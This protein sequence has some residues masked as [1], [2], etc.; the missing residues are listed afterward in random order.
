ML[1]LKNGETSED[2]KL[3][4]KEKRIFTSAIH[5][6]LHSSS[7]PTA[8]LQFPERNKK[9]PGAQKG[10]GK[11]KVEEQRNKGGGTKKIQAL[12]KVDV[13]PGKAWP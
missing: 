12:K 5:L 13:K 8:G 10:G 9:N 11:T 6:L 3:R 7:L 2:C 4:Q 1:D